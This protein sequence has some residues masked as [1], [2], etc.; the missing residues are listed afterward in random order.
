[1]AKKPKS[2]KP[3]TPEP[4]TPEHDEEKEIV[5]DEASESSV[6]PTVTTPK[7][8]AQTS[9]PKPVVVKSPTRPKSKLP[10]WVWIVVLAVVALGGA[11]IV[12]WKLFGAKSTNTNIAVSDVNVNTE[13]LFSRLIDGVPVPQDQVN[14][15]LYAVVIENLIDSRPPSGLD[16]AS[17]VYE[18]L[19]EGGITRFLALFASGARTVSEIGPVR[20]A[21]PYFVSWA[22][23]YSNPLF[24]HAGGSPEALALLKLKSTK[25]TDFNQ[26]TH[27][28]N[29]IRDGARTAPHNLYTNYTLLYSGMQN[30]A[31]R[32]AV[33][34]YTSWTFKSEDSI[35]TRPTTVNDVVV[36]FSSF[37]YKVTY[38]YDRVQNQYQRLVAD[39]PH[40]TRSGDQIYV[41]DIAV[42]YTDINVTQNNKG[43]MDIKT[44]GTGKLLLFRDGTTTEGTWK[45]DSDTSRIQFL[46]SSGQPLALNPG[47]IW[48][49][50]VPTTAVVTH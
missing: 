4:E 8:E 31:L 36:N 13:A 29:F 44:V 26:F 11:A 48:I 22:Q 33:P 27:G 12:G 30:T 35:D 42:V 7:S 15:N 43:R 28:G 23:E 40:V 39:K 6:P 3:S 16:K 25:V 37:N 10:S 38:K 5:E 14:T 32:D 18:T 19:A 24:I 2:K 50:V 47:Q 17:V 46:D 9:M 34:Q 20:S 41:K 1:M 21:R 45:K 49:E